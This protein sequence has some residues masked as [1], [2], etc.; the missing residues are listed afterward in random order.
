VEEYVNKWK[1]DAMITFDDGGIS[2]HIN[3]RAVATGVR[4]RSL[5]T[6]FNARHFVLSRTPILPAYQLTTIFVLR[7]YS[8]LLDLPLL[9]IFSIPRLLRTMFVGDEVGSWGLMVA[10]PS[11]YFTA[12]EA[13]EKHATQVVWDRY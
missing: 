12:R 1:I 6:K 8:I 7:K 4:Y 9:I 3:H 5:R 2:G 11:M 10:S 13:F